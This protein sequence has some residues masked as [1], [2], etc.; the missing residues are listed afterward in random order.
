L[1][2]LDGLIHISELSWS[3]IDKVED[4][5]Q[6]EQEVEVYVLNV[7]TETGKISLSLKRLEDDPWLKFVEKYKIG[8]KVK[9]KI[10]RILQFGAFASVTEGIEGLIHITE[11]SDNPVKYAEEAVTAGQEVEAT[12][13]RLENQTHRLALSLKSNPTIEN[14]TENTTSSDS[15]AVNEPEKSNV[16]AAPEQTAEEQAD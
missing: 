15:P 1:G 7:N 9:A 6:P 13:I 4:I 11:L 5:L 10:S 8:D 12:I 3:R 2:E 16:E 14:N